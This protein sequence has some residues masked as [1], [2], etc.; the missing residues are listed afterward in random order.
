M[1]DSLCGLQHL[2]S[3]SIELLLDGGVQA[4]WRQIFICITD[5]R[6]MVLIL[7]LQSYL[8]DTAVGYFHLLLALSHSLSTGFQLYTW[9]QEEMQYMDVFLIVLQKWIPV[10]ASKNGSNTLGIRSSASVNWHC[11]IDVSG[12]CLYTSWHLAAH[13]EKNRMISYEFLSP[14]LFCVVFIFFIEPFSGDKF[15]CCIDISPA[16]N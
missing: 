15:P 4:F 1:V 16:I 11:S 13:L 5:N 7:V 2:F 14:F 12:I 10:T 8:M 6:V 3:F 9:G